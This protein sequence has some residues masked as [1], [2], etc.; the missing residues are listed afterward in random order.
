MTYISYIASSIKKIRT[1]LIFQIKDYI[2]ADLPHLV[3]FPELD[4]AINGQLCEQIKIDG[5]GEI[6]ANCRSTGN[7]ITSALDKI[8]TDD[9]LVIMEAINNI[10]K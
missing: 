1:E 8:S 10:K 4:I 3:G 7:K 2:K 5:H 6:V 9:L